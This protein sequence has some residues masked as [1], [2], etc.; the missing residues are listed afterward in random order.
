[1]RSPGS[2]PAAAA[3]ASGSAEVQVAEADALAAERGAPKK[4]A[5][6]AS[7]SGD[8]FEAPEKPAK[9]PAVKKA[10]PKPV[11]KK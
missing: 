4:A 7:A 11:A 9:K 8:L 6:P 1:M 2:S 3:G 5:K 10:A